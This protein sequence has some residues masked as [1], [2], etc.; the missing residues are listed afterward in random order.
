MGG[1]LDLFDEHAP[2]AVGEAA[3]TRAVRMLQAVESRAGHGVVVLGP[4]AGGLL[5]HEACGHGLEADG[6][7]RGTSIYGLTA[8]SRVAGEIVTVVDEPG[9]LGG[10]GSYRADDE[11]RPAQRTVLIDKGVQSSALTDRVSAIELGVRRTANGRRESY[12]WAPT[13]RMSNTYFEPGPAAA[14]SVVGDVDRGIYIERLSGG[15]VDVATGEF[16]LPPQR[17]T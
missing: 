13:C 14:A 10:F 11:G 8:G 5:L 1:G 16:P 15:D 12:A 17:P 4:A 6:L 7:S 9:L 2:E 3:A